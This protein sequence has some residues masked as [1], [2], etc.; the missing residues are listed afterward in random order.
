MEFTSS[1]IVDAFISKIFD[2]PGPSVWSVILCTSPSSLLLLLNLIHLLMSSPF[3][4]E[5]T[6]TS[7]S[8]THTQS[9]CR[10]LML[11]IYYYLRP[12]ARSREHFSFTIIINA[13]SKSFS[14]TNHIPFIRPNRNTS[15]QNKQFNYNLS[16]D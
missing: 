1:L 6:S 7:S 4:P 11:I 5:N 13:Y 12:W 9:H 8:S 3:G 16:E 2:R 15:T 14:D 10:S